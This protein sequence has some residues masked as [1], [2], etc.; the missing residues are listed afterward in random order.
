MPFISLNIVKKE[1]SYENKI[2]SIVRFDQIHFAMQEFCLQA[3]TNAILI[4]INFALATS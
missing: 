1:K 3:N 2:G 4:N